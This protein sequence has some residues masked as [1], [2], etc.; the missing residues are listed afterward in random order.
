MALPTRTTL[1]GTWRLLPV[2]TFAQGYYSLAD[3][4]WIGQ[5]LPAHWQQHP[6]LEQ[7]DGKMVYRRTFTLDDGRLT[8]D[9]PSVVYRLS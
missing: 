3:E 7:Y 5:E 6:L 4:L 1:N 8:G 9:P 2:E